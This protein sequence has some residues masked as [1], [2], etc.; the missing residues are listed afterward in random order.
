M[1]AETTFTPR[2]YAVQALRGHSS[3]LALEL[4]RRDAVGATS[5]AFA[6]YPAPIRKLRSSRLQQQ[7]ILLGNALP[8]SRFIIKP[9]FLGTIEVT[10]RDNPQ[11]LPV[12]HDR[13][14]AI[15]PVLHE[16]QRFNR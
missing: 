12:I 15:S 7:D 14:V 2:P 3:S 6:L 5:D 11:N 1:P 9:S 16:P 4:F 8:Q 10:T 13:Q